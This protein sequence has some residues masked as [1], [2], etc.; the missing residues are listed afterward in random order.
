MKRLVKRL[1]VC[2]LKWFREEG[3]MN[4]ESIMPGASE[5]AI[6]LAQNVILEVLKDETVQWRPN[7][8]NDDPYPFLKQ[9][10]RRDFLDLVKEG[11]AYKRAVIMSTY[12][13]DDTGK[14][15]DDFHSKDEGFE[16]V[17]AAL[18]AQAI[19]TKFAEGEPELIE[20]IEA[21]VTCGYIKPE[22][23]C[24]VLGIDLAE[25]T[26]RRRKLMTRFAQW[27]DDTFPHTERIRGEKNDQRK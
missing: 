6:D 7:N 27:K 26:G 13:G 20:T 11:R 18:L 10:M 16:K 22:D 4:D 1:T 3:L 8:P 9:V 21:I 15:L 5:S 23:I 14:A 12:G 19:S 2:A 17:D 24:N 25:Y